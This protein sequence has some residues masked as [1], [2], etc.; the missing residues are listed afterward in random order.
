MRTLQ[1]KLWLGCLSA[2]AVIS[3]A[4]AQRCLPGD[5]FC[6]PAPPCYR[7]PDNP[8]CNPDCTCS[9]PDYP[10]CDPQCAPGDLTCDPNCGNPCW[11]EFNRADAC[12]DPPPPCT[13]SGDLPFE[14]TDAQGRKN[15]EFFATTS[16]P[17]AC[18]VIT[19]QETG[20]Y[21][22]FDT[23]LSE[24][25][26]DQVD[27]TGYITVS[28]SCNADGW[29]VERNAEE[30]FLVLDS[31]NG[32]AGCT[33]DSQCDAGHVCREG[34]SHGRC[35]VP[36]QPVFV[37]TF[38]LV[39]GEENEICI[40]HWCPE[41]E[42]EINQGND[43][44]FVDAEAKCKGSPNSIHFRIGTDAIACIDETTLQPCSW[45]C[46]QGA[47]LPDPCDAMTCEN[48]CQDGTCTDTNPCASVTC[49]HGCKRGLCLQNRFARGP[50]EDGDGFSNLA[51][52]DDN[53]ATANPDRNEVC[54]NGKDDNCD[55]FVDESSC[56]GASGP[57]GADGG[58]GS[59]SGNGE[60]D[61]SGCGCRVVGQKSAPPL[62]LWFA[63]A[64]GVI[65]W[66]RRR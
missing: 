45:G 48:F 39:A 30:R 34:N 18:G 12:S 9:S 14:F 25:C 17:K 47:C 20:Y 7:E 10:R 62:S 57:S 60:D 3:P 49:M 1:L 37:G 52:C 51:D 53:D 44:G 31:D 24:S 40:N 63:L 36:E 46:E 16:R 54:D 65:L 21:A 4:S 11:D 56:G 66:R 23:E 2:V 6:D 15:G 43:F 27:E 8:D 29:A 19:V 35:C 58:S 26:A 59:E 64:F 55:G 50:D 33:D 42:A 32:G 13:P 5:E 28:N 38:L 61:G 41:F 22:I